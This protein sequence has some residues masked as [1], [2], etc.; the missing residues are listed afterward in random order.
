MSSRSRDS[1]TAKKTPRGGLHAR[2]KISLIHG[3]R[4]DDNAMRKLVDALKLIDVHVL[5]HL[6][7]G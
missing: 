1:H 3:A 4:A 2:D 6:L 5:N 7:V